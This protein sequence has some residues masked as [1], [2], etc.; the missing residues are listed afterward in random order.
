MMVESKQISLLILVV[1]YRCDITKSETIKSLSSCNRILPKDYHIVVWDNSQQRQSDTELEYLD[2]SFTSSEYQCIGENLSLAKVYNSIINKYKGRFQFINI[3]DQDS[4]IS[5]NYYNEFNSL[6]NNNKVGVY[7]PQVYQGDLL[8][9]P[10]LM[11]VFRGRYLRNKRLGL[12][13]SNKIIGISSGLIID[14]D[15]LNN[16][17]FEENLNLYGIDTCFFLDYANKYN[18]LYVLKYQLKHSMSAF[19]EEPVEKKVMRHNDWKYSMAEV[20]KRKGLFSALL[21]KIYVFVVS[22]KVSIKYKSNTMFNNAI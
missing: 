10:G 5:E 1:L 2:K 16:V 11:G 13:S 19:E 6:L 4:E 12:I 14:A 15:V 3:W 21:I 9:S 8:V 20:A 18:S 22:V 7:L 17:S